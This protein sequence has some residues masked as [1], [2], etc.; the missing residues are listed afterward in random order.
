M[1]EIK[2]IENPPTVN[3]LR[4][5]YKS[6]IYQ[7]LLKEYDKRSKHKLDSRQENEMYVV[8]QL[9]SIQKRYLILNIPFK[10]VLSE[11]EQKKE[12]LLDFFVYRINF[13]NDKEDDCPDGEFPK[14]E[15]LDENDKSVV[16]EKFGISRASLIDIFCEFYL[17]NI[18]NKERLL[19]Y[20]KTTRMPQAKKH[21]G[22]ITKLYAQSMR[23]D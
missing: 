15:E 23:K 8:N 13:F 10:E 19:H 3:D 6:E 4:N 11:F 14:G 22:Q 7:N 1:I 21:A 12:E 17:L 9:T 18:G 2:F 16:I 5:L 20:L